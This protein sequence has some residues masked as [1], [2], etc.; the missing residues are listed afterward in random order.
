MKKNILFFLI[1]I[2]SISCSYKFEFDVVPENSN[3][4]IND[5][6]VSNND[7][8]ISK[9]RVINLKINKRGYLEHHDIYKK[10]IPFGKKKINITLEPEKYSIKI[11]TVNSPSNLL[12]DSK[13]MGETPC[14]LELNYGIY[15]MILSSKDFVDQK[16]RVEAKRDG[17]LLFRH[18]KNP[19]YVKQIGIFNCGSLPK[20]VI[21][22]PDNKYIYFLILDGFG[23]EIFDIDT[24]KI[25]KKID[26]PMNKELKG[27]AE[28]LFIK[29]KNVFLISQMTTG[30]IYEY[31]YPEN[32][33]IR[34][35]ETKGLWSKFIAWSSVL[36][37][38]AVSNWSSND[39]SI[40]EYSTGKLIRKIPTALAPRGLVFSNDG[41]Y[42][43]VTSFDGGRIHKFN[44]SNWKE[45]KYI[46]KQNGAM[47]HIVKTKD[48]SKLYVSNMYHDEIY[49][50]ESKDFKII[51]TFK[52][53]D[54]PNTIELTPDDKYLYVSCRGKNA[55]ETYLTRSPDNGK[56]V[57]I[58]LDKKE[59][60]Y[61]I[62]GGN[63]PTGL[64][65]S[66]NGNFLC[67]SNFRDNN[68]EL[69][70]IGE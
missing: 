47:R 24:L 8:Y 70:W 36:R 4:F 9:K 46:F 67:F 26:A 35:I 60:L 49:E 2:A 30:L 54:N 6:Q 12:F 63:Q 42:L 29:G 50:I 59:I 27:F 19:V 11:K 32:K 14:K 40:I 66:A 13:K 28:G 37:V 18:Q 44:T 1:I 20:Q 51:N 56:I 3:I 52:V 61:S 7:F 64:G 68:F 16:I 17:E 10:I 25:I 41:R 34:T 53:F 23:F 38:I 15:D 69:Y 55:A 65:L 39:V 33:F 62:E 31:S 57:V 45:E 58:D 48:D 22:S 21:F 5:I 43:Y